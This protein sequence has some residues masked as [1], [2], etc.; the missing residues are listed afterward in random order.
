MRWQHMPDSNPN[1]GYC[2]VSGSYQT[3][4]SGEMICI[5]DFV[6]DETSGFGACDTI[7][8][9]NGCR[10]L[11]LGESKRWGTIAY[12][13]A[14]Y[15]VENLVYNPYECTQI[16]NEK[17]ITEINKHPVDTVTSFSVLNVI[18]TET[19]RAEHIQLA[20]VALRQNG[21][22]FFKIFRRNNDRKPIAGETEEGKWYQANRP[23]V[24][25]LSEVQTIF[26]NKNA[27][28]AP[29]DIGNT[30]VAKKIN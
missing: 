17:T 13:K 2:L 4:N 27:W 22:A 12:L 15:G 23:A 29:D 20:Y 21:T 24:D 30:I 7:P 9:Q 28:V 6:I 11:N 5:T 10:N 18:E 25:F 19:E 8:W 1:N 16:E 3:R 26:G 14:Q